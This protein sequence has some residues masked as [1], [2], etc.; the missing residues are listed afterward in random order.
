MRVVTP[1]LVVIVAGA[2]ASAPGPQ[3]VRQVA[4]RDTALAPIV[5]RQTDSAGISGI[6]YG[7]GHEPVVA[8]HVSLLGTHIETFADTLGRFAV[9]APPGSYALWVRRI[10]YS[11]RE[12]S[13]RVPRD[14]G[15]YLEIPLRENPLR[16]DA[17]CH[18]LPSGESIC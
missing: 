1:L 10:G 7:L 4:E 11:T 5:V 9:M 17:T 13:I 8:A 18:R 12:D 2:C 14:R 3:H 16:L 15:L 6:V